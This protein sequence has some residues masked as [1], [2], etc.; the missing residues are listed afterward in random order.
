MRCIATTA[1]KVEP[2][3]L[4]LSC[5]ERTHHHIR[6]HIYA[7]ASSCTAPSSVIGAIGTAVSVESS[8]VEKSSSGSVTEMDT[9]DERIAAHA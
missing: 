3:L 7:S 1:R 4:L 9:A 8:S 6:D 5:I 2:F